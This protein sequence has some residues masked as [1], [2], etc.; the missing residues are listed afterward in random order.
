MVDHTHKPLCMFAEYKE[1]LIN[2]DIE[3]SDVAQ[4]GLCDTPPHHPDLNLESS[5]A[6]A[7]YPQSANKKQ[8]KNNKKKL[9]SKTKFSGKKKKLILWSWRFFS[10]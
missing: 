5:D 8:L 1:S 7:H 4:E 6:K 2:D 3:A 9:Q 10:S